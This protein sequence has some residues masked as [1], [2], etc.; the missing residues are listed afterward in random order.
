VSG[1]LVDT[2]WLIDVI[3]GQ[4]TATQVL[5]DLSDDGIAVGLISYGELYEGAYYGRDRG[6]AIAGC[7]KC[8]AARCCYR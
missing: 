3:N 2:D 5:A 4:Q 6:Q 1:Y 8:C 7:V